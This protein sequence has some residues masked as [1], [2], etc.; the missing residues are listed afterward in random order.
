MYRLALSTSTRGYEIIGFR[1]TSVKHGCD[2][3]ELSGSEQLSGNVIAKVVLVQ[4]G[5]Y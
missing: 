1:F 5:M 4:K 2:K 3:T